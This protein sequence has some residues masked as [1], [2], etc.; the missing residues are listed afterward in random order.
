MVIN[1]ENYFA[2]L[3]EVSEDYISQIERGA[4]SPSLK[5]VSTFAQALSVEVK[6]LFTE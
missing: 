3:A 4:T 1:T 2:I 6:D 5:R